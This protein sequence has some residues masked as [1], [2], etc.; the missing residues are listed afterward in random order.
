MSAWSSPGLA[1]VSENEM[2][3]Q[4]YIGAMANELMPQD[5]CLRSGL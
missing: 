2:E 5:Q 4:D 1:A 3:I